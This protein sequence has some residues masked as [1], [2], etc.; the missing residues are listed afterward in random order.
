M[1]FRSPLVHTPHVATPDSECWDTEYSSRFTADTKHFPDMVQ[2]LDK[3]VGQFVDK[4]KKEGLWD[5]TIF[6][7]VGDNG[8]STRIKSTMKDGRII[9][10]GKGESNKFG[11]NVP[12]F[13]A[14]GD[15]IKEGRT[16]DRL[17]DL[18]DFMPTMADAMG[19]TVPQE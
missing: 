18:T 1:L 8:T 9:Q 10:G 12:L 5:N 19:V 11:T 17:V 2:Y 3:Q 16:S 14:W 15:K 6:I 4:L 7:F 13:I